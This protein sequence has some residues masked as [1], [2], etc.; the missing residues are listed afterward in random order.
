MNFQRYFST[1]V[2]LSLLLPLN[3]IGAQDNANAIEAD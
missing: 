3:A 2:V 1:M